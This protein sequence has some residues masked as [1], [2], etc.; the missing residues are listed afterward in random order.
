MERA[1]RRAQEAT[2]FAMLAGSAGVFI[3]LLLA[4]LFSIRLRGAIF[5]PLGQL[6]EAARR[7]GHGGLDATVGDLGRGEIRIV[8]RAFDAMAEQ[9]R[10]REGAL[11]KSERLAAVGQL[12][13]GVA[14]EINNP[15]AVIRGYLKTMIPEAHDDAQAKELTILDEEAAACQRIVEDLLTY[16]GDPALARELVDAR[17]LLRTAAE[18]FSS[19]DVG[20]AVHVLCEA[21]EGEIEA[22]PYR[23]RQVIDNLLSNAAHLSVPGTAVEL[24]G[25]RI[26]D[27][28][29]RMEVADR[30][31][32][33]PPGERERVFEPFH[34]G[35]HG[36]TGLGLSLSR[37]IVR[38][39][40]GTI[41]A[42]ERPGGGTVMRVNFPAE[43][44]E[45]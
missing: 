45:P 25:S 41:E 28:G 16:C 15:I 29:Y 4:V 10:E 18:R 43:K 33:I 44:R 8:A 36:G 2:R 31:P 9:L 13:A 39:H 14:H 1:R 5:F 23:L 40:G 30:G 35:R 7:F 6:A 27:G 26:E 34:T 19:T 38:A 42:L 17:E 21:E 11:V 22:D 12:A 24:T 20:S 32:G 3:I 37:V